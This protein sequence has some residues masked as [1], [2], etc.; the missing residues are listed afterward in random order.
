MLFVQ[1]RL[2]QKYLAPQV[3]SNRGSNP[4]PLDHEE[5]ISYPWDVQL[6]PRAV[7]HVYIILAKVR[8]GIEVLY[9]PQVRSDRS[10]NL[11]PPDHDSTFHV[12][13]TPA[14][15]TRPSVISSYLNVIAHGKKVNVHF[16]EHHRH[17]DNYN[18]LIHWHTN[19]KSTIQTI[20]LYWSANICWMTKRRMLFL[21]L[22]YLLQCAHTITGQFVEARCTTSKINTTSREGQQKE[23]DIRSS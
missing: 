18:I 15:T 10:L 22:N 1:V 11:W 3:Q 4:W 9:A 2:W 19:M 23:N 21:Y 12:T 7:T 5:Y 14:L 8:L 16:T 13:E 17:I 20:Y 6:N